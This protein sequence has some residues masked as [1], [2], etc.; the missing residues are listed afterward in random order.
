MPDQPI[1]DVIRYTE[2]VDVTPEV[3]FAAYVDHFG[4]WWPS[5]YTFADGALEWIGIEPMQCG[6]CIER[7]SDGTEVVWGEV[8]TYEPP[9]RIVTSWWIQPDRTIDSD[10]ERASEIEIRFIDERALTRIEFEHRH[11]SRHGEGWEAMRQAMAS[12]EGWPFLMQTY[13]DFANR[14]G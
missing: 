2:I 11:L 7:A 14:Q 5:S 1:E 12:R 10:P 8:L 9:A 4:T 6:R 3:A 13:S